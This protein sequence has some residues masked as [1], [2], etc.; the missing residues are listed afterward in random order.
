MEMQSARLLAPVLLDRHRDRVRVVADDENGPT[1]ELDL[2]D[3]V[4]MARLD[5][6]T[7]LV[8]WT[9]SRL[10]VQGADLTFTTRYGDFRVVDGLTVA[11]REEN[12]AQAVMT[13][14]LSLTRVVLNPSG[15]DLL[16]VPAGSLGEWTGPGP[17]H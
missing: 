11:H 14:S 16:L 13:A 2:A 10:N 12:S 1:L 3:G 4:L 9:R 8:R 17:V 5:P 15:T 6:E 7:K